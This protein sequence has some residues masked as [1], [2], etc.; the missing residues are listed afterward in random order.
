VKPKGNKVAA[1]AGFEYLAYV[2][3]DMVVTVKTR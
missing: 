3:G 1:D 2:D